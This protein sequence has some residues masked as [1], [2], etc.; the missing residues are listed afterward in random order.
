MEW[1]LDCHRYPEKHLRP[2]EFITMMGYQPAGDQEEIGLKLKQE[3]AVKD[4]RDITHTAGWRTY[5]KTR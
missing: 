1:C 5:L 2:R 4:A 3:Y